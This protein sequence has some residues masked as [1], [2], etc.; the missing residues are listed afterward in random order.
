MRGGS[1]IITHLHEAIFSH[2][3]VQ[4]QFDHGGKFLEE[5]MSLRPGNSAR[6]FGAG[7]PLTQFNGTVTHWERK[8]YMHTQEGRPQCAWLRTG[9]AV[10]EDLDGLPTFLLRQQLL[11][12]EAVRLQR[13]R[14]PHSEVQ[15]TAC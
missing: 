11:A 13:R 8:G 10:L 3:L 12:K 15:W 9:L 4:V 7:I 2:T 6:A 5:R 1:A 14:G